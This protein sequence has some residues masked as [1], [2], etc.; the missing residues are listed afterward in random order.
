MC[1]KVL[2][3]AYRVQDRFGKPAQLGRVIVNLLDEAVCENT[4]NSIC[5]KCRYELVRLE[6]LKEYEEVQG[7]QKTQL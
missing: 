2:N 4:P 7:N 5:Q 1:S 3:E 6:K